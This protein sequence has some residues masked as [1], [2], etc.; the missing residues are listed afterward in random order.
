[1]RYSYPYVTVVE[2]YDG[3]TIWVEIDPGFRLTIKT[4]VRIKGIQAPEL[5]T[6]EGKDSKA[7]LQGLLHA[8]DK[9]KL[10]SYSWT[11]DRLECDV[12][13]DKDNS[14]VATPMIESGHA[15]VAK[16]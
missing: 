3:D 16:R 8:G 2:V 9:V 10:V 7:F 15:K 13:F 12:L 1:M 5:N 6:P 4:K 14:S 11:Y